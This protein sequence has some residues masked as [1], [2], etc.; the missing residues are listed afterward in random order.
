MPRMSNILLARHKSS[1]IPALSPIDP[2]LPPPLSINPFQTSH[3]PNPL[4]IR[5]PLLPPNPS[6][7]SIFRLRPILSYTPLPPFRPSAP[8]SISSKAKPQPLLSPT[9]FEATRR[10]VW[11]SLSQAAR[12]CG[13]RGARSSKLTRWQAS[14]V[15][16]VGIAR[17]LTAV[18]WVEGGKGGFRNFIV[19]VLKRSGTKEKFVSCRWWLSLSLSLSPSFCALSIANV[20]VLFDVRLEE[21]AS[22]FSSAGSWLFFCRRITFWE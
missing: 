20:Q 16:L 8:T 12:S 22:F 10:N 13:A 4:L 2:P 5:R 14:S 15:W 21:D 17:S 11:L 9:P 3:S 6:S 1:Q 7:L 18:Q 19:G